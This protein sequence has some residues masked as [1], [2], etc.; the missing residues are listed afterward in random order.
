[1]S[2][3]TIKLSDWEVFFM[4]VT[5]ALKRIIK[6]EEIA[7]LDI[8]RM[9]DLF[10]LFSHVH[11]LTRPYSDEQTESYIRSDLE[12]SNTFKETPLGL[13][14]SRGEVLRNIYELESFKDWLPEMANRDKLFILILVLQVFVKQSSSHCCPPI[15][16]MTIMLD[17]VSYLKDYNYV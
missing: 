14:I 9:T 17:I 10:Y 8:D 16:V 1:M 12:L 15:P 7:E 13:F 5:H 11:E 3:D 6:G 4:S 2:F